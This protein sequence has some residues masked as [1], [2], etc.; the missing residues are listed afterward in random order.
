MRIENSEKLLQ[1]IEDLEN[2]LRKLK[3]KLQE[4][5]IIRGM[6]AELTPNQ[7]QGII[8]KLDIQR[9]NQAFQRAVDTFQ[10]TEKV[11]P[12]PGRQGR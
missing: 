12:T 4:T 10:A 6:L 11:N 1:D 5:R 9:T 7:K 8:N 2:E 3:S